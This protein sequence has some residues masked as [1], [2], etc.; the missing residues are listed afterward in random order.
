MIPKIDIPLSLYLFR[1][2]YLIFNLYKILSKLL[3]SRLKN[4]ING[5]ISKCQYVFL[6]NRKMF[7]GIVVVDE[8]LDFDK[9]HNKGCF[10]W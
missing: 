9:R 4:V 10:F 6:A 7:D 5:L 2:I 1:P 3:A 8:I